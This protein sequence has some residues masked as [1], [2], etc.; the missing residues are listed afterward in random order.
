MNIT[1]ASSLPVLTV[2]PP[3]STRSPTPSGEILKSMSSSQSF[4]SASTLHIAT[5][6]DVLI[7]HFDGYKPLPEDNDDEDDESHSGIPS[8]GSS[9]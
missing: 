6:D 1:P 2:P 8:D 9:N 3:S 4:T 5:S 7:G